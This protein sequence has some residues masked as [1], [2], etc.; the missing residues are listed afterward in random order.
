MAVGDDDD[1]DDDDDDGMRM[2][3]GLMLSGRRPSS[4]CTEHRPFDATRPVTTPRRPLSSGLAFRPCTSTLLPMPISLRMGLGDADDS[5]DADDADKAGEAS[6]ASAPLWR[7]LRCTNCEAVPVAGAMCE[8][9]ASATMRRPTSTS[10][11]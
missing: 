8:R 4:S 1:D 5:D 6:A 2:F 11:W 7:R 10:R 3:S 9:W